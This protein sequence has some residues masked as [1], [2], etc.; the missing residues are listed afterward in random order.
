MNWTFHKMIHD[1]RSNKLSQNQLASHNGTSI[2]QMNFDPYNA[3]RR[4]SYTQVYNQ[5][6]L[7]D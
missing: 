4:D 6:V 3:L 5:A 1:K 2:D 7:P